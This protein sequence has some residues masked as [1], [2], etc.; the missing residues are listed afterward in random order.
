M[1]DL[2]LRFA[3]VATAGFA[4]LVLAMIGRAAA[5]RLHQPTV[6]GEIAAGLVA[7]PIV[8]AV[9]DHRALAVLLPAHVDHALHAVSQAALT[10]LLVGVAYDLRRGLAAATLR[11]TGWVTAGASVP[12]LAAGC[13]LA[14]WVIV[15]DPAG[16]RSAV[17]V[18]S[19]VL[20][21]AV[22]MSVTAVPVL[23]R[24]LADRAMEST[25]AGRLALTS[26]VTI[27]LLA[28][29]L[30]AISVGLAT[31]GYHSALASATVLTAGLA[32]AFALRW[33]GRTPAVEAGS[34]R[35]PRASSSVVAM[36]AVAGSAAAE[37][38]GVT[39][40]FGALL[41]GAAIP[42]RPGTD[43]SV[44]PGIVARVSGAGLRVVPIFFA[45]TGIVLFT[46]PLPALPWIA[47]VATTTLAAGSKIIGSYLGA[48]LAGYSPATSVQVGALMNTRGLTEL[49]VLQVGYSTG[50]LTP[51]MYL[52]CLVMALTT[53]AMTA[54]LLSAIQLLGS[55]GHRPSPRNG[56]PCA[57]RVTTTTATTTAA[58][59]RPAIGATAIGPAGTTRNDT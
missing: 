47:I 6:L 26:A 1:A 38:W 21:M 45:M 43:A 11:R 50:I 48:R 24:I 18:P 36:V 14:V 3:H 53:T 12:S 33:L 25:A 32:A 39:G 30:L 7:G 35:W 40:I 58:S 55:R 56:Q 37:A 44:W 54:P 8:V 4:V 27:D 13:L 2:L 29:P 5:R 15:S 42:M 16:L 9:A 57:P 20:F 28:W 49:V 51:S 31:G 19:F 23:A 34:A 22:A 10:L 17:P 52:A 59:V 46:Q 41:V